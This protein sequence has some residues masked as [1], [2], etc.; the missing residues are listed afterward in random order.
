MMTTVIL[1]F[2][3]VAL[4]FYVLLGGADFGAGIIELF[5]GKKGIDVIS[6]VIAPVW[7]A[8][9]VWLIVVIVILFMGFPSVYSTITLTLHIPLLVLL[10]GIILRGASFTFRYYD[11]REEKVTS[12]YTVFFK[13]S[14][15]FTP[16]FLGITLGAVILGRITTDMTESFYRV[17]IYPWL[18]VFSFSVGLFTVILFTFLASLYLLGEARNKADIDLFL[19]Y[20][21]IMAISLVVSGAVVFAAGEIDGLHLLQEFIRSPVSMG[22]IGMATLLLPFLWISIHRHNVLWI[23]LVAGA[24]TLLVLLGWFAIQY[25]VLV[26]LSNEA[27]ITVQLAQAPENTMYQ[28]MMAL[29]VGLLLVIPALIYLFKVFKFDKGEADY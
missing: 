17:F 28:L 23:R 27:D 29:I 15:L 5:T 7:E 12:V 26:N 8:N 10:I 16:M 22:S 1:L 13:V 19:R 6:K 20:S 4:L 18:N 3:G 25:P 11:I 24:Q 14:S 21:R 9:H 2:L